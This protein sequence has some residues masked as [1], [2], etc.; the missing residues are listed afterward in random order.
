MKICMKSGACI[1][2]NIPIKDV[3]NEILEL[4]KCKKEYLVLVD[5]DTN[6]MTGAININDIS[7][8]AVDGIRRK[9]ENN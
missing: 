5:N 6:E 8:M 2:L 9:D 7:C 4:K 3:Y 1:T